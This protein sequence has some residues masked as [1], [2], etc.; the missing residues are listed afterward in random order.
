ML[1]PDHCLGIERKLELERGSAAS[2]SSSF[3]LALLLALLLAG[4]DLRSI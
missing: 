1:E 4:L 2:F 3:F